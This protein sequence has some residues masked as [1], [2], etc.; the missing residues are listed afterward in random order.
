M[1]LEEVPGYRLAITGQYDGHYGAL[2]PDAA[3]L[4]ARALDPFARRVLAA[5]DLPDDGW[6]LELGCGDGWLALAIAQARPQMQVVGVDGSEKAIALAREL[7]AGARNAVF[8]VGSAEAPPE[9]RYARMCATSVFNLLPDKAAALAAWRHVAARDARLVIADGFATRG[10]GT[11]G[12]GAASFDAFV[13]AARRAG[14]SVAHREDLTPLVRSLHAARVWP[15][16]EYV[17]DRCRYGLVALRA[18]GPRGPGPLPMR[19]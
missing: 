5:L 3:R 13:L 1:T 10:P 7:A 15:W 14:W 9:A 8:H 6:H 18:E 17:R 4:R 12:A 11:L 16:P 19:T 2:S